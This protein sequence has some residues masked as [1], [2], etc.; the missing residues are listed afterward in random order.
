MGSA[1]AGWKKLVRLPEKENSARHARQRAARKE[2]MVVLGQKWQN[3]QKELK[4][5]LIF[6]Y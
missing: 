4:L 1:A 3:K 2:S 5:V 6:W